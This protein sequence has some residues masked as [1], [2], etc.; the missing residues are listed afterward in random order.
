MRRS[1]KSMR[2][3]SRPAFTLIELLVVVAI[4]ALLISILLPSLARARELAKRTV[5]AANLKGTGTGLYTYGNENND[6]WPIAGHMPATTPG[7]GEVAYT[8]QTG[9]NQSE[10]IGGSAGDTVASVTRNLYVLVKSGASSTGSFICPSSG[11]NKMDADNPE[12]CWDFGGE[13]GIC[14]ESLLYDQAYTQISYAY[15]VPYGTRGSPNSDRDARMPLAADQGPFGAQ[16]VRDGTAGDFASG[17]D[18]NNMNRNSTP[19]EW[20]P[21]NSPNHGGW[22]T[23][24]GQNVLI[25]DAHVDWMNKPSVGIGQDNIYTQWANSDGADILDR[26][27]GRPPAEGAAAKETPFG[28]TDTLLYP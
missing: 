12:L 18:L 17:V 5:C 8:Q 25:V 10:T 7:Q 3:R 15:Q 27:Q 14:D 21:F 16:L 9:Q 28:D 20:Q 1:G 26:L 23:G 2:A 19:E 24:E 11:D 13:N 22:G 4:I 6:D